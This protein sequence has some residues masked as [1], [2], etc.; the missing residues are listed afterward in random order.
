MK[1]SSRITKPRY[2]VI[3]TT[4]A[5]FF[6]IFI[7]AFA[8]SHY[9]L[10]VR[11]TTAREVF[12]QRI[13]SSI[14]SHA[15]IDDTS[16]EVLARDGRYSTVAGHLPRQV[17]RTILTKHPFVSCRDACDSHWIPF[18]TLRTSIPALEEKLPAQARHIVATATS[19]ESKCAIHRWTPPRT[20]PATF[21]QF[22]YEL[23]PQ[24]SYK[25]SNY[26]VFCLS[27]DTGAFVYE[28][29]EL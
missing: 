4:L 7:V 20:P 2:F 29:N 8:W 9:S 16:G 10:Q 1:V 15:I 23:G 28:L 5:A 24:P 14:T 21:E 26:E 22:F 11:P 25:P 13:T 17:H 12:S 19:S 3:G 18:E 6:L 27:L